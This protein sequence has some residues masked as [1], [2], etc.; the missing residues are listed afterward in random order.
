MP[1]CFVAHEGAASFGA[2]RT[3]LLARN[4]AVLERLHP[5]YGTLVAGWI[6]ADPLGPARR[7]MDA[8]RWRAGRRAAAAV[9]VTHAGGGGVDRV[10]ADRAAALAADGIRPIVLRPDGGATVVDDR[11]TPNLRFRLPGEWDGLLRLLRPE[12]VRSVELH[13]TL[14]HAP[15]I[16]QLASRLGAAQDV[17]VHDYALFCARIA[18]VP[19][20][21]YCGEPDLPGCEACVAAHGSNLEEAITPAE[22]VARSATI[23]AG[24]R[25]AVVPSRDVATRLRRHFPLVRPEVIA[26][27]DD[28]ALTPP[29]P[30]PAAVRHVCA[31]GG[32]GVEKG[33]EVLLA[34]VRDAA[35]RRLP[36]RFTV[37]GNTC[38]DESLLAAGPVFVTGRYAEA[39]GVALVRAQGADLALLPS[40]WPETWCFTLGLAWQAGLRAAVFDIGTPAERVRRTGWGHVL[41]LGMPPGALNDWLGSG[42]P[43]VPQAPSPSPLKPA[44]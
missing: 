17:F 3:H 26:W 24:A 39:E 19:A 32:I 8:L 29:P 42:A 44:I 12:R 30:T 13:H 6:A 9:L 4:G 37:V 7:R 18:L 41:P 23:L 40:V 14:G 33:F 34:C 28:A 15:E 31:V 5:G 20:H 10:V 38:D 2:A 35:A 27:Q 16:L 25:R 1:G 21:S 36:L 22:L 11:D 43:A